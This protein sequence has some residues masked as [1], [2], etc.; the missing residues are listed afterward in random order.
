MSGCKEFEETLILDVFGELDP[1]RRSQWA[2]HAAAC[3]SCRA[4]RERLARMIHQ[5][6]SAAAPAPLSPHEAAQ[7]NARIRWALKNNGR[8]TQPTPR[9]PFWKGFGPKPAWAF[10]I[11]LCL[12]LAVSGVQWKGPFQKAQESSRPVP[13]MIPAAQEASDRAQT[14][15]GSASTAAAPS[16]DEKLVAVMFEAPS[17][18][19]DLPEQDREILENLD[20]LKEMDTIKKLVNAV[21]QDGSP[22]ESSGPSDADRQPMSLDPRNPSYA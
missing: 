6:K 21:D 8:P 10:G 12:V 20:F 15:P 13:V 17:P 22:T 5:L 1:E 4:Q 3:P 19:E 2:A 11:L 9:T 14:E 16:S 7:M 18:E